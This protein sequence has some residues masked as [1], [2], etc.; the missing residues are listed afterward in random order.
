MRSAILKPPD[1][2]SRLAL[3]S[4][5]LVA[6]G[7]LRGLTATSQDFISTDSSPASAF[8][9]FVSPHQATYLYVPLFSFFIMRLVD[10]RV[11]AACMVRLG[12]RKDCLKTCVTD[13]LISALCFALAILIPSV[14]AL[15]TKSGLALTPAYLL[16]FCLLQVIYETIFFGIVALVFLVAFL[17]TRSGVLALLLAVVYGGSDSF[18]SALGAYQGGFWTG[19]KLMG[20]ADPA[21]PV[22]AASGL[23]R[24]LAI[25]AILAFA[26]YRLIQSLDVLESAHHE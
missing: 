5:V 7:V 9:T 24:L 10:N 25:A 6:F 26:A 2:A 17:A 16:T 23:L 18:V 15:A 1:Y 13:S 3:F 4:A 20:Y 12:G 14:V 11:S 19:W 22:L 8:L 21:N